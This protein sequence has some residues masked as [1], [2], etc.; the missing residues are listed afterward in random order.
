MRECSRRGDVEGVLR[1]VA[2]RAAAGVPPSPHTHSAVI[3]AL[4]NAGRG[5]EALAAFD[6]AWA[7]ADCRNTAVA[8]AAISACARQG[9]W[10]GARRVAGAME[11][12]RVGKDTITYNSLMKAAGAA[13]LL[14]EVVSLYR[15]LRAAPLKPSP[16][17]F[18][19]VYTAAAHNRCSDVAWLLEVGARV[20]WEGIHESQRARRALLKGPAV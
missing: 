17:T 15:E 7:A 13:G 12:H 5:A 3:A 18:A 16:V 8:N 20:S 2:Q 19:T 9:D 11:R 6:A 14:P 10:D 1:A 4:G